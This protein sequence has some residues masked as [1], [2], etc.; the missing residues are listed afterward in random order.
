MWVF[1]TY[2]F[3]VGTQL[4]LNVI[5]TSGSVRSLSG[6]GRLPENQERHYRGLGE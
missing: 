5:V 4:G 2:S 6:V 3:L 1:K